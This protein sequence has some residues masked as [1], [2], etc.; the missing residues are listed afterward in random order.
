M[1]PNCDCHGEPMK[2]R[3]DRR[4]KIGGYWLCQHKMRWYRRREMRQRQVNE[5]IMDKRRIQQLQNAEKAA[6][7]MGRI[8]LAPVRRVVETWVASHGWQREGNQN[9]EGPEITSLSPLMRLQH[10][11]GADVYHVRKQKRWIDFD[12]ADKIICCIDPTLWRTDPELAAI[13]QDLDLRSLDERKPTTEA[14]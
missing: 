1:P 10:W 4:V 7:T 2:W 8:P 6:K 9:H 12:L 3:T 5:E 13:Y 11:V 14:A